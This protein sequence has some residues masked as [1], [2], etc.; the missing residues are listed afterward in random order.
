MSPSLEP[1]S[2][3]E[4]TVP[5]NMDQG[6]VA[7]HTEPGPCGLDGASHPF[8]REDNEPFSESSPEAT[9]ASGS[10]RTG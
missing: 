3:L 7:A 10:I 6:Q 9:A 1:D 8:T 4:E 2:L 5:Q